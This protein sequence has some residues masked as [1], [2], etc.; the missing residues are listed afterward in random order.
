MWVQNPRLALPHPRM[1]ERR[2]VMEPLAELCPGLRI[3][4]LP[5]T[6]W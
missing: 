6:V 2:F 4:G 5:G 3:A 1:G